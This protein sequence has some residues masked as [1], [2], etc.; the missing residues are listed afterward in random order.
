MEGLGLA[1]L[2]P[3]VHPLQAPPLPYWQGGAGPRQL[4][5]VHALNGLSR[6]GMRVRART[7]NITAPSETVVGRGSGSPACQ[8]GRPA[9]VILANR[10]APGPWR[11]G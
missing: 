10:K 9:Q 3:C 8:P 4:L 7:P 2:S 5:P 11:A 1:K 6:N